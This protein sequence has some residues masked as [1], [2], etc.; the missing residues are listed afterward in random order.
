MA[1]G[2]TVV[3]SLFRLAAALAL[4]LTVENA[5]NQIWDV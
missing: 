5:F 1:S 4:L 3:G 2:R